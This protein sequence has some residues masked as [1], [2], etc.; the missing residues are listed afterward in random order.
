MVKSLSL[1]GHELGKTS[2]GSKHLTWYLE[3]LENILQ[4]YKVEK[5]I[6]IAPVSADSYVLQIALWV[7][8]NICGSG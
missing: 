3:R 7:W 1:P 6:Q 8:G 5:D 4:V 2:L